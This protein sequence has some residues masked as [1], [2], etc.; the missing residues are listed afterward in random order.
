[1]VVFSNRR[2]GPSAELI[3]SPAIAIAMLEQAMAAARACPASRWEREWISWLGD[4]AAAQIEAID[5][6]D[7]AWTPDHFELQRDFVLDALARAAHG[8][9]CERALRAWGKL[10]AAHPRDAVRVGRRWLIPAVPPRAPSR[11]RDNDPDAGDGT[12]GSEASG[13]VGADGLS[14]GR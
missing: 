11:L 4:L 14:L 8:S 13:R 3:V 2:L 10:I 1:M 12:G 5:V 7:F 6:D 9:S